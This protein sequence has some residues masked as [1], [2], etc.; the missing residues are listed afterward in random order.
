M[1]RQV[2]LLSTFV[3]MLACQP[4]GSETCLSGAKGCEEA[5]ICDD[6]AFHCQSSEL[7]IGKIADL[8]GGLDLSE[9]EGTAMDFVLQ[10]GLVTVVIDALSEAHGLA[11][12]GGNII[13][14]GGRGGADDL[15]L[16]YQLAG[17]LPEDTF[18][19]KSAEIVDARPDMVALV[20]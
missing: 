17:I 6:L 7:F 9:A 4:G 8:P 15:N 1:I 10:N 16:I 12:T 20:L 3:L 13:D 18:A 11:P 2:A 19:Y 14:M 5:K